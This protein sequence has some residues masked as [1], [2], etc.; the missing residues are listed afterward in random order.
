MERELTAILAAQVVG[1]SR[2]MG[3]P[4]ASTM[5]AMKA[6]RVELV[7]RQAAQHSERTIWLMGSRVLVGIWPR[8]RSG[9]A[10]Q[11]RRFPAPMQAI[12]RDKEP[13]PN[14]IT[15]ILRCRHLGLPNRGRA[16]SPR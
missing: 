12:V 10:V 6:D 11:Y 2:A 16:E 7:E 1:Y 3:V 4:D 9:P 15:C 8:L 13:F 14:S 5:G